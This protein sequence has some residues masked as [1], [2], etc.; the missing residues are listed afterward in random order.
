MTTLVPV[1]L[2]TLVTGA[3][4]AIVMHMNVRMMPHAPPKQ[5]GTNAP[6]HQDGGVINVIYPH[7]SPIHVVCM[8]TVE[9]QQ[10]E[11]DVAV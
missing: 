10:V 6:V 11:F 4:T 7:A 9:R 5:L 3:K 1:N 8:V 2:G